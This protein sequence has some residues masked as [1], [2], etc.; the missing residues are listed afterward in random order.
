[1][2]KLI[3]SDSEWREKLTSQA[4]YVT[5]Q[6][7]TEAPFSGRYWDNH[8][9]GTYH[10]VCCDLAL[11]ASAAKFDSGSGWPSFFQTVREEHVIQLEDRSLFQVRTEVICA[12]CDAHLG[13]VFPD[14]PQPTG[15]R[16]C[17][18]SAA[19]AFV[20]DPTKKNDQP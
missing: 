7:G 3:Y 17:I 11:F 10:C 14:G 19:L 13:H 8:E 16:Y 6:A 1:M 9:S 4:F 12:R 20:P 18:N 5:R 15:L 2:D